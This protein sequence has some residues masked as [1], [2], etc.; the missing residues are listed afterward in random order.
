MDLS[1]HRNSI[2]KCSDVATGSS[3]E[4]SNSCMR[5]QDYRPCSMEERG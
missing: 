5:F 3:E 4:L 2:S 1:T